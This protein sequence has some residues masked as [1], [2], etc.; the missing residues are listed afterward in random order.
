MPSE[1][2]QSGCRCS[3]AEAPDV[4]NAV[5]IHCQMNERRQLDRFPSPHWRF[6][7]PMPDVFCTNYNIGK[8]TKPAFCSVVLR[9]PVNYCGNPL[10]HYWAVGGSAGSKK[11]GKN[12][13]ELQHGQRSTEVGL[14][15]GSREDRKHAQA[16]LISAKS[17]VAGE[18]MRPPSPRPA[19][20]PA[21]GYTSP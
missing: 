10:S 7:S 18:G 6:Y 15:R 9:P 3:S 21:A 17:L 1:P 11:S 16:A 13:V 8:C 14:G 4:T 2:A 19:A 5:D 12:K 20:A